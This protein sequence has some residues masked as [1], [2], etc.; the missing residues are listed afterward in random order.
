MEDHHEAE[1]AEDHGGGEGGDH[2]GEEKG[3]EGGEDPVGEAAE[4]LALGAVAIGEDFRDE[5]PDDRALADG[6]GGDEGEDA[7]GDD[8]VV[9]GV[10][11]PGAE[12]EGSDVAEGAD[13][14]EGA[15]AEA[16]DEPEA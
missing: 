8:R 11:G 4:G 15:A 6:V 14:E 7:S 9:F 5:D 16:V 12:A 3:E 13:V 2:R 1:E 10:E